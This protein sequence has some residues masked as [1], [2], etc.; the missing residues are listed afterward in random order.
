MIDPD[1]L[2][3]LLQPA[4]GA[5][6]SGS[7][8]GMQPLHEPNR[9]NSGIRTQNARDA[10]ILTGKN[11]LRDNRADAKSLPRRT[12]HELPFVRQMRLIGKKWWARGDSNS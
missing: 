7:V 2:A 1:W 9:D 8:Y 12:T 10:G 11:H 5:L 6:R 3:R 4:F